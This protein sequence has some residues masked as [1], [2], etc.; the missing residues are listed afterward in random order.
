MKSLAFECQPSRKLHVN[1]VLAWLAVFFA[2]SAFTPMARSQER[3]GRPIVGTSD[4]RP[5]QQ[6]SAEDAEAIIN[7][8]AD[9]LQ[10]VTHTRVFELGIIR[11]GSVA[12][13]TATANE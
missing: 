8:R 6:V 2:L 11:D 9:G 10:V 3:F 5:L 1:A 7:N 12:N 4:D 13:S